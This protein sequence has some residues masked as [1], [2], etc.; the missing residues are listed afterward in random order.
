[1]KSPAPQHNAFLRT[2]RSSHFQM[3]A[4]R[5]GQTPEEQKLRQVTESCVFGSAKVCLRSTQQKPRQWIFT[6][7]H[8]DNRKC[9]GHGK[10]S[11][12]PPLSSLLKWSESGMQVKQIGRWHPFR[13]P[14]RP[15]KF[16]LSAPS[17]SPSPHSGRAGSGKKIHHVA[18]GRSA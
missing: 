4:G 8:H 17:S 14:D 10:E 1:M 15:A 5:S 11:T 3:N 12:F 7:F 13:V 6:F 18:G 2:M 16:Q 9:H